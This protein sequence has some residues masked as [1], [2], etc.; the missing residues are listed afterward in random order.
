MSGLGGVKDLSEF[1]RREKE[2]Q[3]LN[4]ELDKKSK[5]LLQNMPS[6]AQ[7]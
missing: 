2:L 4:E 6:R 7:Y 5:N 1:K 3:K